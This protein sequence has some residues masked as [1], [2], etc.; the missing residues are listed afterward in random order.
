MTTDN[1]F[2]DEPTISLHV[3]GKLTKSELV[4]ELRRFADLVE[5]APD[6]LDRWDVFPAEPATDEFPQ[7]STKDKRGRKCH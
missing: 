2:D 1:D 7:S 3:N 4:A 5:T 6:D